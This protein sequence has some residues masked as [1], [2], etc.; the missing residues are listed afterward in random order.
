M[1]GMLLAGALVGL[2]MT[3]VVAGMHPQVPDLAAAVGRMAAPPPVAQASAPD[4]GAVGRAS[5]AVAHRVAEALR[6][7]RY[8]ADLAI[9]DSSTTR[10]ALEKI[11]YGLVG[12]VFPLLMTSILAVSGIAVPFGVPLLAGLALGAGMSLLP[13][14][15]LRRRAAVAR[16]EMRRTVC[17]YLE[18]V[19]LERAADAGAVE[20]LERAAAIGS[21]PGFRHIR[22]A[23]LRARLEGRTPWAQLT[24]LAD[25]MA[26]PELGDVADIMRLSGE[27]GAAVLPTLRARAASLRTWMLNADVAA[28]NEASERM[29]IP[30]ALLGVA[31]MVLLGFPALWR[32]LLG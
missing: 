3:L 18:L 17:A 14:V 24:A 9:T 32:I 1:T 30:V 23:L 6:L 7:D 20:A 28:A 21:G 8:A 10:M 27:D 16:M 15:D 11:G 22:D 29:S 5:A 13:E 25:L 19:A 12:L 2:G 26:V 31:F 4:G